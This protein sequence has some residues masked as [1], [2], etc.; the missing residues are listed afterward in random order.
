MSIVTGSVPARN[1]R[2]PTVRPIHNL[3]LP[4]NEALADLR[5]DRE[6]RIDNV[7]NLVLEGLTHERVGAP[8]GEAVVGDQPF[9]HVTRRVLKRF[10]ERP[11]AAEHHDVGLV[12]QTGPRDRLLLL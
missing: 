1:M 12:L 2:G 9:L 4:G 10:E 6:V 5:H 3:F 11:S 7:R 8:F